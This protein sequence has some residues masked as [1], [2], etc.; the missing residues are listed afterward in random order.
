[1]LKR[2]G[3]MLGLVAV[4]TS[5]TLVLAACGGSAPAPTA[6]PA[7]PATE[8]T[9]A[10]APAAPAAA[11]TTAA[12]PAAPAVQYPKMTL[13]LG[14]AGVLDMSY[15]KGNVKFAELIKERSGGNIEIQVFP[16]SQLGSE[17]DMVEQVKSGVINFALTSPTFLAT[18]EGWGP[19][20]VMMMPY[21][22]GRH[23]RGAVPYPDEARP[24]ARS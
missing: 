6:A 21:S 22:Q 11:P 4:A 1:M 13:K 19:I 23:R 8:P 24:R 10:A 16:N 20:G 17:K 9:K 15:H 5:A 12:A 14:H 18:Y 3:L 2:S 7:K